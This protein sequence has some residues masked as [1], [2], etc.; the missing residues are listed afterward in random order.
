MAFG[1]GIVRVE[2]DGF[3]IPMEELRERLDGSAVM[4][5]FAI[6]LWEMRAKDV[7]RYPHASASHGVL[8]HHRLW[9]TSSACV[10]RMETR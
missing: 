2:Y 8:S 1:R 3:G 6:S 9:R 10:T 7:D 4:M 5:V